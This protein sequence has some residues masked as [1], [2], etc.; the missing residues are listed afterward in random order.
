MADTAME[1]ERA[2]GF[3][4]PEGQQEAR[5]QTS[6]GFTRTHLYRRVWDRR[7]NRARYHRLSRD[8]IPQTFDLG[9]ES[10]FDQLPTQGWELQ[11][12]GALPTPTG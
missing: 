11:Y 10:T 2:C 1:V 5:V 8:Q 9:D 6:Y 12:E 3:R 4:I 7:G